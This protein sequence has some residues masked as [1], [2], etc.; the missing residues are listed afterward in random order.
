MPPSI[1]LPNGLVPGLRNSILAVLRSQ[2]DW[3]TITSLCAACAREGIVT[4]IAASTHFARMRRK[5]PQHYSDVSGEAAIETGRLDLVRR[6]ANQLHR[7]NKIRREGRGDEAK[8]CAMVESAAT[9]T[10]QPDADAVIGYAAGDDYRSDILP[11]ASIRILERTRSDAGDVRDLVQSIKERGLTNPITVTEDLILIA[12]LRRLQAVKLLDWESIPVRVRAGSL[13]PLDRSRIELDENVC[14][15]DLPNS[16]RIKLGRMIE[17]EE[18]QAAK[19]RQATSTGGADPQLIAASGKLPEALG[20]D[21]R[22]KIGEKIG[23]SG[24]SYER[25]KQVIEAAEQDPERFGHLIDLLNNEVKKD[26]EGDGEAV[27]GTNRKRAGID[28]AYKKLKEIQAGPV[29]E[30]TPLESAQ[31]KFAKF[32]RKE[33]GKSGNAA[34]RDAFFSWLET[35]EFHKWIRELKANPQ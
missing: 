4:D 13:S 20:G 28:T 24:K 16:E 32:V 27:A 29:A 33:L 21:T 6:T 31:K 14:R 15:L 30:A 12:G 23:L 8:F 2:A 3:V 18:R 19:K 17:E 7:E 22:D 11:V 25:G 5:H 34:E 26:T 10:A 35:P 1:A 9:L